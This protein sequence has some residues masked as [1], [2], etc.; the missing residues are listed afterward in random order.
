MLASLKKNDD[1]VTSGGIY[2]TVANVQNDIVTLR[3]DDNTKIKVQKSAI[4]KLKAKKE[5]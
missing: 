3:I 2:G 1:V 5:G 4:S